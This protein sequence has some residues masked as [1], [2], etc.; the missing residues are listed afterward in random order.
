MECDPDVGHVVARLVHRQRHGPGLYRRRHPVSGQR[1]RLRVQAEYPDP[2]I[3]PGGRHRQA[4]LAVRRLRD[5]GEHL[6]R[7]QLFLRRRLHALPVLPADVAVERRQPGDPDQPGHHRLPDASGHH[8]GRSRRLSGHRRRL[9]RRADPGDR[10]RFRHR[11]G[12]ARSL[13]PALGLDR[14]VHQ[15]HL[16]CH[17]QVRCDPGSALYAG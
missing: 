11:S 7:R 3:P 6:A 5:A 16:A 9:A 15:Q 1:R 17:R 8:C 12:R 14:P 4:G 10:P 13:Q 2:G